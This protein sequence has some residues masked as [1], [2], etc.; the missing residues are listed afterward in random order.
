MSDQEPPETD[1]KPYKSFEDSYQESQLRYA[2]NGITPT[3][4]LTNDENALLNDLL[5]PYEARPLGRILNVPTKDNVVALAFTEDI[6][7]Q[8]MHSDWYDHHVT[9][10][11]PT[12]A[13][14]ERV[15]LAQDIRRHIPRSNI[16]SRN[17]GET[18]DDAINND[19]GAHAALV[20]QQ[21]EQAKHG[22]YDRRVIPVSRDPYRCILAY[23]DKKQGVASTPVRAN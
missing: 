22:R 2:W 9:T 3:Q 6:D 11:T 23:A 1:V 5:R 15:D 14:Q 12:T 7:H 13:Y 18:L 10:V 16:V 17:K 8:S 20:N 4:R 21:L 19:G